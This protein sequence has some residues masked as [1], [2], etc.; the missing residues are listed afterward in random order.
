VL[1]AHVTDIYGW[2]GP[3]AQL[4]T[5][6]V[7]DQIVLHASGQVFTYVVQNIRDVAPS[8]LSVLED[9]DGAVLTLLTCSRPNYTTQT[10]DGRLAVQAVLVQPQSAP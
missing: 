5:L 10:Y 3:F 6:A 9:M 1:T 8:D 2:P 4:N 7:G